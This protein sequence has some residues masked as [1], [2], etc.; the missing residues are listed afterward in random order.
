MNTADE[1]H[2]TDVENEINTQMTQTLDAK[3]EKADSAIAV[4]ESGHLTIK[5]QSQLLNVLAT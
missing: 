5:E 2:A 4:A 3:Y 1:L